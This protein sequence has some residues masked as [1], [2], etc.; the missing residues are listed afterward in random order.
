MPRPVDPHRRAAVLA[1][2]AE[3][4]LERGLAGLSLR[5]LAKALGT[6][7]RM[8]LYDFASQEQLIHEI[9][10]EIRRREESLLEAEVHTLDDVWRWIAAPE[11]EP[12][13]RLFFEIYVGALG[14]KE[15]EPLVRDWLEFLRTSWHPPVDE[16]TATLMVAV[17]RGLLLDRLATG[18]RDRTDSA[19]RRFAELV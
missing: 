6:S 7:T 8:L 3:Y 10:A 17:V 9:L 12:F 1:K 14:R 4:V 15:A 11:R 19:L 2:A 18:D 13:L 16:V 5:P